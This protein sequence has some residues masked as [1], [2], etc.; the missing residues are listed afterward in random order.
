MGKHILMDLS[1]A[2]SRYDV[3]LHPSGAYGGFP[4]LVASSG[5][6]RCAVLAREG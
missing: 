6:K 5:N 4:C 1:Y 3:A 2:L